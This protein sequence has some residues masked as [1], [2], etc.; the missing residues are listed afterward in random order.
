MRVSHE[1]VRERE[2]EREREKERMAERRRERRE[3]TRSEGESPGE[4]SEA[5]V[6]WCRRLRGVRSKEPERRADEGEPRAQGGL[7]QHRC[8]AVGTPVLRKVLGHSL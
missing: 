7:R 6:H 3:R 4:R 8:F 2:C 5:V 1:N